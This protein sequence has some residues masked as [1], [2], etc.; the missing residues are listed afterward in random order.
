M[1]KREMIIELLGLEMEWDQELA[2]RNEVLISKLIEVDFGDLAFTDEIGVRVPHHDKWIHLSNIGISYVP[3]EDQ[4][5]KEEKAIK[6]ATEFIEKYDLDHG[7]S[8]VYIQ[9]DNLYMVVEAPDHWTT[10][11]SIPIDNVSEESI[12]DSF[13][14]RVNELDVDEYFDEL[15]GSVPEFTPSQFMKM[16]QDDLKF[17]ENVVDKIRK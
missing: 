15:W 10:L 8:E 9:D 1:E 7:N 3:R 6:L 11:L 2:E 4:H 13:I 17:Y 16:L 5:V 14:V 12:I